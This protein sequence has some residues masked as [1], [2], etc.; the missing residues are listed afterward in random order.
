MST[1]STFKLP[2]I[3][4]GASFR[5][6]LD[7]ATHMQAVVPCD[8]EGAPAT[9]PGGSAY[10]YISGAATTTVK[11]AAGRL[12]RIVNNSGAGTSATVYDNTSAADPKIAILDLTK[13]IGSI[14]FDLPFA[15]G[16]TIVTVGAAADLTVVYQ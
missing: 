1:P 3:A 2:Q 10:A 15:T 8:A 12:I 5:T 16:L 6:Y 11:A 9:N 14:D 7:G 13:A 4:S